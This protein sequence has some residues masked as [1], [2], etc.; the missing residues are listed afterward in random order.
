[1]YL[2]NTLPGSKMRNNANV[3][4]KLGTPTNLGIYVSRKHASET[5]N[6]AN[7]LGKLRSGAISTL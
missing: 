5:L 1:M 2:A 3:L 6:N 7:V 4:G